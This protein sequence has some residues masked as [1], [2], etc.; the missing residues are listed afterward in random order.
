MHARRP[1]TGPLFAGAI[2]VTLG[3]TTLYDTSVATLSAPVHPVAE[4]LV[5]L[6]PDNRVVVQQVLGKQHDLPVA[7]LLVALAVDSFGKTLR[8]PLSP[9]KRAAILI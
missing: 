3:S 4:I 2:A 5:A 6:P 7:V 9:F 8:S 1:F